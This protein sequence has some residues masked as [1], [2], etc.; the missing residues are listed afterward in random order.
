MSRID[1]L[2]VKYGEHIAVSWLPGLSGAQKVIFAVY[3][4][5]DERRL[6]VRLGEFEMRTREANRSWVQCDLTHAFAVWMAAD[7]YRDAYFENPGDLELKLEEEFTTF[8]AD[9]VRQQLR[10]A[11]ENAIV[12]LVGAG[13]LYGFARLSRVIKQVEA[14][15]RGRLLVFFPGEFVDNTYRLLGARDG[16]NY[17]ATP[18]TVHESSAL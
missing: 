13:A 7:E 3:D 4:P 16:W 12:A 17:L 15:I 9:Q 18:I 1:D 11:D 14:E 10:G 8:V 2:A 6:R 5:M